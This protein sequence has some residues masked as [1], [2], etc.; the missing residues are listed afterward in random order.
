LLPVKLF[1]SLQWKDKFA[2]L[3]VQFDDH[4][5]GLR[6]DLQDILLA[7]QK[8]RLAAVHQD[9]SAMMTL[10]FEKMRSPEERA[11]FEALVASAGG[12]GKVWTNHALFYD[13][14]DQ[15]MSAK[16][17]NDDVAVPNLSPR[18]AERQ[19]TLA[20]MAL[21]FEKMRSPEERARFEA[22]VA[23]AGGMDKVLANDAL[24]D[25]VLDKF[26]SNKQDA[27]DSD[28][29]SSNLRTDITKRP[30]EVVKENAKALN[31]RSR[32]VL[33]QTQPEEIKQTV[34]RESD[35]V[36]AVVQGGPHERI[37]SL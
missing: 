14:L 26:K 33:T 3:A 27:N 2:D 24:F 19:D 11:R 22:L 20:T 25:D 13:I 7:K 36:M 4:K 30:D 29:K 1:K 5:A 23:S 21:V 8:T 10:V 18:M 37:V 35:R 9:S 31:Q 6:N 15:F 34:L 16:Q 17:D 32:T 28:S 12:L